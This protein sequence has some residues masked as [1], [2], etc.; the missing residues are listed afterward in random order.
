MISGVCAP[1]DW[2]SCDYNLQFIES[3][4]SWAVHQDRTIIF[5]GDYIKTDCFGMTF[6]QHEWLHAEIGPFHPNG[7][8]HDNTQCTVRANFQHKFDNAWMNSE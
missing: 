7:F 1:F 2:D 8:T 6:W 3:D 4:R 5:F